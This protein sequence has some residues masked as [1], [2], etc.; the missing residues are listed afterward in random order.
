MPTVRASL[1]P[2]DRFVTRHIGPSPDETRGMLATLGYE[3]LDAFIDAVVPAD[4]RLRRPLAL[5]PGRTEREVLQ[6]LRGLAAQNQLFRSYIGMGYYHSFTPQV[7]QRNVVENPGWYTAYTPYQPEIAQ[8]RLEALL[9]FQTMV[10]D[11]TALP[12]TNA[13]LL[14]EATAAA[15]AM[16]LT[17]AVAKLPAGATPRFLIAEGCHPQTIAVVRT[18]AEAR[19]VQTVIADPMTFEFRPGV[20]GALLQYPLTDGKIEDY[21]AVCERA[22]AAGALVTVATDLLAL[23][24]LKPP[25]EWGADIAVGNSQRFGVPMGYG[26][27]HAA[28][29]ATREEHKRRVPGRRRTTGAAHGPADARAAHPP[30]EGD[31]QHLHGAGPARRDGEHVR[32]VPRPRGAAPHRR[33]GAH[34]HRTAGERA[35]AV[36]L[37][38]GAL[39]VLRHPVRR[40]GVVGTAAVDRRGPRA[41]HQPAHHLA[42]PHRRVARRSHHARRLG[43]PGRRILAQRGPAVHGGRPRRQGRHR[44]TRRAAAQLVLPHA[45]GLPPLPLRDGDAAVHQAARGPRPVAHHLHDPARLVYHEAERDHR[46]GPPFLARVQPAAPVRAP[47]AGHGLPHAVPPARGHA[48]RDHRVREGVAPAQRRVARRI[49]RAPGDPRLSPLAWRTASHHLPHSH[50]RPRHQSRERGDGR[51]H[52]GAR[53]DRRER[54]HRFGG[55]P[56]QS[57][58]TPAHA[59]RADGDLPVYHRHFRGVH[60]AGVRDRARARWPGVHGR[61]QH[62]RPGGVV[63]AGRH[64]RRCVPLEPPQDVLYPARRGGPGDGA[65]L[66]RRPPRAVPPGPPGR[67]AASGTTV[68]HGVR[69]AVGQRLDPAHFLGVHRAYGAGG[70]GGGHHDGDPQRQLRG[71][72]A[73][74]PLRRPVHLRHRPRGPRMHHRHATLQAVGRDRG[75]RHREADH[76]LRLPPADGVVPGRRDPHD[77][78]NRERV[79]G[80]ARP[81][82]RRAHRDSRRNS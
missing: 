44:H 40:S 42:D 74:F 47:R 20:I 12:I 53:P 31:Q 82:L 81:L 9:N 7:I 39:H 34:A 51:A 23:T 70:V 19:G 68:R 8:G 76:R 5:P 35:D 16:H 50:L 13:S 37:P 60:P 27:P 26:G 58:R 11:L 17:E 72:T 63:P 49:H 45:P 10:A 79:Q 73:G 25:G 36:G 41:P 59:R 57:G 75:R 65:D 38:R 64:G 4:I 46:D 56:R 30:R 55:P 61:R 71:P 1:A 6:A 67:A 29:F 15:E 52:G 54:R 80:G 22:H 66:C 33:A 43:R 69:R 77:R 2:A 32:G 21:R 78:A 48:R 28:F 62:E 24:L 14:D 3:S 18:R